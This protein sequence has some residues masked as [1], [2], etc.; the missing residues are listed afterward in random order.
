MP[1]EV[2][3]KKKSSNEPP[4]IEGKSDESLKR[5]EQSRIW[6]VLQEKPGTLLIPHVNVRGKMV[7]WR[8]RQM[9]ENLE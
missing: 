5:T 1:K 4:M 7:S 2:N 3:L 8:K 6:F 9:T